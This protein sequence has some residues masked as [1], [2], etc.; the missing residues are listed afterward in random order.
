MTI[1]PI[2]KQESGTPESTAAHEQEFRTLSAH[3][4]LFV[5]L[6]T[7]ESIREAIS[8]PGDASRILVGALANALDQAWLDYAK[9]LRERDAVYV[10]L[11]KALG[12]HAP[13]AW[14]RI[15]DR[16]DG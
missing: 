15:K 6:C 14:D 2:R 4:P 11:N 12:E 10:E 3:D 13:K 5:R 16:V 8:N 1:D 9:L 7:Q